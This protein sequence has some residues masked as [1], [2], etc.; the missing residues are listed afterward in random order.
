[1][2]GNRKSQP[3]TRLQLAAL[4]YAALLA[5]NSRSFSRPKLLLQ[6]FAPSSMEYR[7]C[8]FRYVVGIL[9]KQLAVCHTEQQT[10]LSVINRVV[11]N[12]DAVS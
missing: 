2:G 7:Q 5:K 8:P 11:V 12:I 9:L 10:S 1:M 3:R 4:G 6:K